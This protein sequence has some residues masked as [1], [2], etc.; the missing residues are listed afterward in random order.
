MGES[1]QHVR[2]PSYVTDP[3]PAVW[4][5][6][7]SSFSVAREYCSNFPIRGWDYNV[8]WAPHQ[9]RRSAAPT[10]NTWWGPLF[11]N[12]SHSSALGSII[13]NVSKFS[14]RLSIGQPLDWSTMNDSLHFL[15]QQEK[16]ASSYLMVA[17]LHIW[18]TI[19]Q[20]I[21]TK[22]LRADDRLG[23]WKGRP[24]QTLKM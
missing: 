12:P 19:Y 8:G 16:R 23:F 5:E 10:L 18:I 14:K 22:D 15:S 7:V 24:H 21:I 20:L 4:D 3:W 2:Q 6:G 1:T 13:F 11:K 17:M 9:C